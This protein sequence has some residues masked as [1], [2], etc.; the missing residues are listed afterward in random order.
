M[1]SHIHWHPSSLSDMLSDIFPDHNKP[2]FGSWNGPKVV[3]SIFPSC[4]YSP[5]TVLISSRS[6]L[7]WHPSRATD[8][9]S[10][11]KPKTY[12]P[13]KQNWLRTVGEAVLSDLNEADTT[14]DRQ[15]T[16]WWC[17]LI[18]T[19]R[20]HQ[21]TAVH[22]FAGD[23]DGEHERKG[24]GRGSQP[25]EVWTTDT[26]KKW[27]RCADLHKTRKWKERLYVTEGDCSKTRSLCCSCV[28]AGSSRQ[29]A[30]TP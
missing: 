9:T 28:V 29:T 5:S 8:G 7:S 25:R 1:F 20:T 13:N 12:L 17:C 30:G 16:G 2:S 6:P 26:A 10:S 11:H 4:G 14:T 23:A 24:E 22:G 21:R 18:E 27:W 19:T 3:V 15:S